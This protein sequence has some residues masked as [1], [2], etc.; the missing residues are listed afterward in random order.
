MKKISLLIILGCIVF[1]C[2]SHGGKPLQP[3]E[4][5]N[6]SFPMLNAEIRHSMEENERQKDLKD[7]Q[8]QT[9]TLET[10]NRKKWQS[11]KETVTKIQ[12]RLRIVSFSL[13]MIPTGYQISLYAKQIKENQIALYKELEDAPYA[14][15]VAL[16]AQY[17]FID[18]FQMTLR[19]LTGIAI[20]YGAIN[21][22]EKAER[23][24]LL[25]YALDEVVK[26]KN[27]SFD[28]LWIVRNLKQ[29]VY[30]KKHL[31]KYYVNR[32]KQIIQDIFNNV[33]SFKNL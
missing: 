16:P 32:D 12:D 15:V 8:T 21:Q 24:R 17:Q 22:M 25:N 9:T 28:I 31:F 5:E 26:I 2:S 7:E 3:W 13:Q 29:T 11:Y 10:T 1:I 19:L 33:K 20:S 30:T 4:K 6:V 18:D 27:Q 14:L 23:Q